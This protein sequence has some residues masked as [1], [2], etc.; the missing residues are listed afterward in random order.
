MKT[1][2]KFLCLLIPFS[3]LQPAEK[4][5]YLIATPCS[6]TLEVLRM[7]HERGDF[8][9][10][11]I[12][13]NLAYCHVHNYV[14]L[15]EGWYR[16]DAPT[17]YLQ[18]AQEIDKMALKGPVFVGET[19]HTATEFLAANPEL[20]SRMQYV[21]L[22]GNPHNLTI[23]Y[24]EKKKDYFDQ[25]PETQMANSIGLKDLYEFIIS[26]KEHDRA[27][28]IC[29]S[30]DLYYHTEDTVKSMCGHLQ[31]PYMPH[32]LHWKDISE[33]FTTLPFWTIAN[34]SCILAWNLDVIQST[35]FTLPQQYAVDEQGNPTFEEIANPKHRKICADAYNENMIYYHLI[36][37]LSIDREVKS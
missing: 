21:C 13:A 31:I 35:G 5:V 26:L 34:T 11:D 17:T 16:D 28:C 24:Y 8:N 18:A 37:K 2:A 27:V 36:M 14:H 12:P 6:K 20:A 23:S 4:I 32:A 15:V 3:A 29:R 10:M 33:N 9:V 25:M 30:D 19:T 1:F 22:I 7:I